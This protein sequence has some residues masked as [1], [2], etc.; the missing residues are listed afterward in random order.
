[1]APTG[2]ADV[3]AQR[4]TNR[5]ADFV[6]Q[7]LEDERFDRHWTKDERLLHLTTYFRPY[8]RRDLVARPETVQDNTAHSV[9][10]ADR[11]DRL[12]STL[13][14]VAVRSAPVSSTYGWRTTVGDEATA[15]LWEQWELAT[16]RKSSTG[17]TR[18]LFDH[19]RSYPAA[20]K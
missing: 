1:M 18:A 4:S 6:I 19:T 9:R 12:H 15:L 20:A 3:S 13:G 10:P 17:T 8:L 2:A 11:R 5:A 14:N 7:T 16:S